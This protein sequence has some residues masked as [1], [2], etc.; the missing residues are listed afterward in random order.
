[1]ERTL[2]GANHIQVTSG[3]SATWPAPPE[4]ASDLWEEPEEEEIYSG[5]RSHGGT[6]GFRYVQAMYR[7][8]I[9]TVRNRSP[10]TSYTTIRP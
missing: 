4:A 10:Q 5:V 6:A 3:M 2:C 9:D 1:M 7:Y 8:C